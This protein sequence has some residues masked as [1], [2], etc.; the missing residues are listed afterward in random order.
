MPQSLLKNL[1]KHRL[2]LNLYFQYDSSILTCVQCP[3]NLGNSVFHTPQKL[4]L[5]SSA[6]VRWVQVFSH[7]ALERRPG[8]LCLKQTYK[9]PAGFYLF[10]I[11]K[12][13]EGSVAHTTLLL[14][15]SHCQFRTYLS[16]CAKASI[17]YLSAFLLSKCYFCCLLSCS[18]EFMH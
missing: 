15:S 5:P 9:Q 10:P 13:F 3:P 1:L 6:S 8:G 16:Q 17:P 18:L 4:I 14:N 12:P 11:L 2:S 7:V